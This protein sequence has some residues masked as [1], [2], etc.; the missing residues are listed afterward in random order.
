MN[1]SV[2]LQNG[3]ERIG[4]LALF[5][6]A[7]GQY[8]FVGNALGVSV[9]LFVLGFYGIFFYALKVKTD[10]NIPL[11]RLLDPGALLLIP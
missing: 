4:L 7:F 8:L 5:L 2:L 1:D 10:Q 3:Q 6:G 9:L 11:T